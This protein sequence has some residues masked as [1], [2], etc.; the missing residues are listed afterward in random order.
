[1]PSAHFQILTLALLF[2]SASS[3]A[4]NKPFDAAA[5]FGAREDVS[6]M[7]MSPDGKSVA[8]IS[9]TAGPGSVLLTQDL[10]EGSKAHV[11]LVASGK[12]ESIEDCRWVSNVRLVC[13]IYGIVPAPS[14]VLAKM[15]PGTRIVAVDRSG[16][17]LKTL[18]T[19]QNEYSAGLM[20]YG[21]DVVDWLPDD[22]DKVLIS[23]QYLSSEHTGSFVGSNREGLGVDLLDTRTLAA[24]TMEIPGDKT[25][26]YLSDGHGTIRIVGKRLR[27]RS[28]GSDAGIVGYSY[29]KQESRDWGALS[30]YNEIDN[31]GFAPVAVDHDLNVA[32]GYKKKDGRMALYTVALD[33]TMDEKLLFSR[34]DVDADGLYK[35]GRRN[36]IVGVRYATDTNHV[37]YFDPVI[38]NLVKSFERALP[39]H[40]G[41]HVI[42]SSVDEQVLLIFASS[43]DDPGAY[44]IFDRQN[45]QLHAFLAERGKLEGVKLAKVKPISFPAS[46]GT[47]I[48]GYL[49]LPP[50][51]EDAKGLPAIV[52]PHGGPS[53]RDYW[54]FDWLSQF[55]AASGYAV[56]QPNYRGS[57]GY[58]DAWTHVNA[59]RSWPIAIGD[60]LDAGHWMVAQGI[61]DPA[62]L[63][64]VGWSYGGYAAL[65]SAV[66]EPG[67]FK[68]VVAIAPVTDLEALKEEHRNWSSYYAVKQEIGEGSYVR[69][70]SPAKNASKIKVPVLLFHGAHDLNVGIS[71]SRHMSEQLTKAGVKNELVT[72]DYLDHQLDDSDARTQML[73]KSDE[74]LRQTMGG[75]K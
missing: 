57:A 27:P 55:Y 62:K 17:N 47:Q 25:V 70:G 15:I 66:T 45:K 72:W 63:G 58:G 33:G 7:T 16:A 5:S 23:R 49:T 60:I 61:A 12:P 59:F 43:D 28:D 39:N 19:S 35:I 32:Y 1:M 64:I 44:Y 9:P 8:Y 21:G 6:D 36:R 22:D 69:E 2:T 10:A 75:G 56:I 14:N 40:P 31:S 29:R 51:K 73:R 41:V 3:A 37:E 71:E 50:G 24:K 65:Q 34:A 42:D 13:T 53:A 11:T 20:Q 74:F 30:E 4:D 54:G 67:F 26:E 46:D 38:S 48:P 18:S 68:A 52:M